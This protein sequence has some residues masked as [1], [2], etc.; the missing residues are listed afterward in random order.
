MRE[1][2]PNDRVCHLVVLG[3]FLAPCIYSF[4]FGWLCRIF[5]SFPFIQFA[6]YRSRNEWKRSWIISV[7]SFFPL[8][9]LPVLTLIM[10]MGCFCAWVGRLIYRIDKFEWGTCVWAHKSAFFVWRIH[11]YEPDPWGNLSICKWRV[12]CVVR[13]S[14]RIFDPIHRLDPPIALR[15]LS[16]TQ[17]EWR[18][19]RKRY[20][21]WYE[22]ASWIKKGLLSFLL[23][24]F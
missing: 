13:T 11:S 17:P 2:Q 1:Y 12:E 8:L 24:F 21:W 19:T 18:S 5:H 4:F 9:F 3:D 15:V 20:C 14:P 16:A 22:K 10:V 23:I 6:K 7:V